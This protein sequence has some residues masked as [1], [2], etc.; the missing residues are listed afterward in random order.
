MKNIYAVPIVLLASMLTSCSSHEDL[1][2][3]VPSSE[4]TK[5]DDMLRIKLAIDTGGSTRAE[6]DNEPTAPTPEEL[7]RIDDITVLLFKPD[8]DGKPG[9]LFLALEGKNIENID[10]DRRRFDVSFPSSKGKEADNLV[11]VAVA[12]IA[13]K[14]EG[15]KAGEGFWSYEECREYLLSDYQTRM[16]SIQDSDPGPRFTLWGV[17][18]R[19]VDTSVRVQGVRINLV[20]D[21]AR[22]KVHLSDDV[23]N[24]ECRLAHIL[25]F[26]RFDCISVM[27]AFKSLSADLHSVLRPTTAESPKTECEAFTLR[28]FDENICDLEIYAAEQDILFGEDASVSDLHQ[29]ERPALIA[30]VYY[31]GNSDRVYWYRVDFR[32]SD[33]ELTDVL[34]NHCYTFNVTGIDGPGEDTPEEAYRSLVTH[35]SA[36]VTPWDDLTRDA[37]FDGSNWVSYPQSLRLLPDEGAEAS[38]EIRTNV[39]PDGWEAAW[40]APGDSELAMELCGGKTIIL[41]NI[42]S[43]EFP[44]A[45]ADNEKANLKFTA[46]SELPAGTDSRSATLY[47]NVTPK[48]RLVIQVTQTRKV[49]D[50]DGSFAPWH[51]SN[52]FDEF[53]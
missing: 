48:L 16:T 14:I 30:G 20:R 46:L 5:N 31:R 13:M 4:Q 18:D 29:F 23:T 35:V 12:N 25:I 36:E 28:S 38:L 32:Q 11:V 27:P 33:G 2:S 43:V 1:S 39:E 10:D 19:M 21:L 37:V 42:F 53:I 45:L 7:T 17:A 3:G 52:I 15:L 24:N 6:T 50:R 49:G 8:A 34:R 44:H 41:D 47:V 22:I 51:E 40:G 9:T 26:N